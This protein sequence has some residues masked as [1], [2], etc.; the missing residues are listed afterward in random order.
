V[1]SLCPVR[2]IDY[3][4][5]ER[6]Y[7]NSIFYRSCVFVDDGRSGRFLNAQHFAGMTLEAA[8]RKAETEFPLQ[9]F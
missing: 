6:V 9:R 7:D 1:E 4:H 8:V 3:N 5:S 2:V